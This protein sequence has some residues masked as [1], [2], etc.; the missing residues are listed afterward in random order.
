MHTSLKH[1]TDL[2]K[3][4]CFTLERR[5]KPV[6]AGD[7]DTEPLPKEMMLKFDSAEDGYNLD[8]NVFYSNVRDCNNDKPAQAVDLNSDF[9]RCFFGVPF[10]KEDRLVCL[11]MFSPDKDKLPEGLNLNDSGCDPQ[12][13]AGTG[14]N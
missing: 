2:S 9:S 5:L 12:F 11:A 14:S 1:S 8:L 10:I 3:Q 4:Q 7:P 13:A 6:N